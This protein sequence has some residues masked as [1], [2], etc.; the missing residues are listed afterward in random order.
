MEP[1]ASYTLGKNSSIEPVPPPLHFSSSCL[2][3]AISYQVYQGGL[4][5]NLCLWKT[6]NL[7][8]QSTCLS[9][10]RSWNYKFADTYSCF[11]HKYHSEK[12]LCCCPSE[13][14]LFP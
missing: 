8:V 2:F 11:I 5:F 7:E 3:E 10:L 12:H 4:E 13:S 14:S 1:R 9:L 6:L